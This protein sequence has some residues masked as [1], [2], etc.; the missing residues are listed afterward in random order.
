MELDDS[1][2]QLQQVNEIV[3]YADA[4]AGLILT[5]NGVLVG[6]V[7]VRLQTNGFLDDHPG[8]AALL[9]VAMALLTISVGFDIAAVM[10]RL[11][12][13]GQQ[14]SLLHFDYIGERF[15]GRQADFVDEFV[16][17]SHD[18]DLLQREIAAQVWANS[19]VARRKHRCV[20]WGLRFLAGALAVAVIAAV[21]GAFG[22]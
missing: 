21:V 14:S 10:P 11:V 15:A 19:V 8:S 3:R 13:P 17:L 1:W 2:K 20:Q 18:P 16:K 6:L 4:K 5:L 7:A 9:I 12:A 22:G